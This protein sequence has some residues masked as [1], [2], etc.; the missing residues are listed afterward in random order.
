MGKKFMAMNKNNLENILAYL[1]TVNL[2]RIP[3]KEN[4]ETEE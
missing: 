3:S 2:V 4:D 1:F